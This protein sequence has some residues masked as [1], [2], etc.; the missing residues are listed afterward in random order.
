VCS[1]D[2]QP[3]SVGG[4]SGCD[5]STAEIDDAG[6]WR[7][8]ARQDVQQGGLAGAVRSDDA[9]RLTLHKRQAHA[10]QHRKCAEPLPNVNGGEDR[11]PHA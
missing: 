2:T 9:D 5:I 11:R 10:V 6:V 3:A 7:E 1:G 4:A 8:R